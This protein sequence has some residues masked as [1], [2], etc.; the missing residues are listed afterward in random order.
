MT[1]AETEEL[2]RRVEADLGADVQEFEVILKGET[3]TIRELNLEMEG[4]LEHYVRSRNA[5]MY[6]DISGDLDE[7]L[8]EAGVRK[9]LQTPL[10]QEEFAGEMTSGDCVIKYAYEIL[11]HNPGMTEE[12]AKY[13]VDKKTLHIV[14]TAIKAAQDDPENP[15]TPD[16]E[17]S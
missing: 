12:R 5:Q 11:K 16:P 1:E 4:R 8:R 9:I 6:R 3:V 2:R 7:E 17:T 15:P 10:S 14:T 13:L